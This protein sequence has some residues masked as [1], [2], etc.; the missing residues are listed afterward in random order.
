MVVETKD[1]MMIVK[2]RG[3]V[4]T[5]ALPI[6]SGLGGGFFQT[7]DYL[8]PNDNFQLDEEAPLNVLFGL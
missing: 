7:I 6:R 2:P 4:Q 5:T 8:F 3:P 1:A